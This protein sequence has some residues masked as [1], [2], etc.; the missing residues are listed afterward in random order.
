MNLTFEA[1]RKANVARLPE[2]LNANGEQSHPKPDGSDWTLLEWAGA[3][4]GEVGELANILKKVRRGDLPMDLRT[5][6]EIAREIADVQIYLDLLAFVAGVDL[7]LATAAKFNETSRKVGSSVRITSDGVAIRKTN[8]GV[9]YDVPA[10]DE[11]PASVTG[12]PL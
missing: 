12:V 11:F 3:L 7:A 10:S 4:A 9:R 5:K 6:M 8:P 1:L 2:F